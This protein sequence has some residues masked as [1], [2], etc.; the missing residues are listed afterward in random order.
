VELLKPED[1]DFQKY[2]QETEQYQKVRPIS[3]FIDEIEEDLKNPKPDNKCFMPW[4]SAE[5]SFHFRLGEVT[6]YAGS[7]GGGKSLITGQIALSLMKQNQKVCIASFEMKPKKTIH[8]MLRQFVGEDIDNPL[9]QDRA[10]EFKKSLDK[11]KKFTNNKFW[12]YDQQGTITPSQVI[13]VTRYC[14]VELGIQH[15]FIDSLMKCMQA[16]DDYN[17]QKS[18]VDQ[19]TSIARDHNAHIHLVHHIRK[20]GNQ[21]LMPSKT[22]LKGSGAVADQVD[23]VF[24]MHRNKKKEHE[25]SQGKQV[26]DDTADAYLMC[27]KQR[28][29]EHEEWYDLWYHRE[30]QQFLDKPHGQ[31]MVFEDGGKF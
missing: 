14:V 28:N 17:A 30:S 20:L 23:N 12:L 21:E 11:F 7:N 5:T 22:D 10:L 25:M 26:A 9:K 16:E 1:I 29:G 2:L 19:L 27:E 24:L 15:M 31:V 6:V 4:P 3:V 18:F 13:A 8:R